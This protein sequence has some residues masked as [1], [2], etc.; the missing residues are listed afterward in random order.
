MKKIVLVVLLLTPFVARGATSDLYGFGARGCSLLG[1]SAIADDFSAVYYNPA[2]IAFNK[3]AQLGIGFFYGVPKLMYD[4]NKRD[5][6][7]I[8]GVVAG[9]S[10]PLGQGT[11]SKAFSIGLGI[12]LPTSYVIEV[13]TYSSRTPQFIMY[14]NTADVLNLFAAIAFR[15][16]KTL[17]ISGGIEA[18]ADLNVDMTM[19]LTN[20]DEPIKVKA[21]MPGRVAGMAGIMFRPFNFLSFGLKFIDEIM[22]KISFVDNVIFLGTTPV[23][24]SGYVI[25]HYRPQMLTGGVG[26]IYKDILRVNLDVVFSRYSRFRSPVFVTKLE[27]AEEVGEALGLESSNKAGFNDT[28]SPRI[29]I[30]VTPVDYLSIRVGYAYVPSPVPPQRGESNYMDSDKSIISFGL[31]FHFTDPLGL[32][33]KPVSI[34][35][36][37]QAHIL[38]RGTTEKQIPAVNHIWDG[39]V[40]T[41]GIEMLY[42]F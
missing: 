33:E 32:L 30:E 17:S 3:D 4:N 29:G 31:G 37:F 23:K 7:P 22:V 5:I 42:R 2:G 27:G 12:F 1:Y 18:L 41:M 6:D 25:D 9:Y 11:L 19:N 14:D 15:P 21:P 24:L 28:V 39:E 38:D 40:Y 36:F 10:T 26:Y 16:H 35:S 13:E 20:Q 34:N 8:R